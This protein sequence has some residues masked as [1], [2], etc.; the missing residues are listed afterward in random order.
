MLFLPIQTVFLAE[1]P[2]APSTCVGF[3]ASVCPH[4]LSQIEVVN[5]GPLTDVTLEWSLGQ[6]GS[7]VRSKVGLHREPPLTDA[8]LEGFVL[9]MILGDVGLQADPVRE[10]VTT[11]VAHVWSV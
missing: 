4:V 7:A 11:H 3:L 6:V 10:M 8:T 9:G 1:L 5:K 2:V